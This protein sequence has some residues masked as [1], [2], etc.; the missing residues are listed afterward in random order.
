[1]STI[2][3]WAKIKLVFKQTRQRALQSNLSS[4]WPLI[5]NLKENG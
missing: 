2:F 4:S 1:M 5:I 3:F